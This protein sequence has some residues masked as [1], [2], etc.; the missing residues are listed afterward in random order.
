MGV[1]VGGVIIGGVLISA[2]P[3][4]A[5]SASYGEKIAQSAEV[6]VG[7]DIQYDPSYRRLTYP[8]GDVPANKGV[9]ADVVIRAYR[10]VGIDFQKRLHEDMKANFSAYPKRWQLS[11]PDRTIDHRRVLNLEVFLRRH[12]ARRSTSHDYSLYRPGDIVAWTLPGGLP[13]MGIVSTKKSARGEP[14]IVHHIGGR[15]RLDAVLFEWPMTGHY[16]YYVPPPQRDR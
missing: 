7:A 4:L 16:R 5:Q 11:R 10:S 6:M 2:S 13:H 3:A 14:L 15:P 12:G 8:W 1:L 9:C